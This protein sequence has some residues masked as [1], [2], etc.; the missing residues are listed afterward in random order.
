MPPLGHALSEEEKNYLGEWIR[1]G[2]PWPSG[3]EL[4]SAAVADTR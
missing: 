2:A 1:Q 4:E 3:V